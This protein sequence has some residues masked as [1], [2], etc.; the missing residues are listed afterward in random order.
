MTIPA[1]TELTAEARKAISDA[2][3]TIEKNLPFLRSLT[4][5]ERRGLMHMGDRNKAFVER[6]I[7]GAHIAPELLPRSIVIADFDRQL[8]LYRAL[9][10]ILARLISLSKLIEDTQDQVGDQLCSQSMEAYRY[11]KAAGR[12]EGL[13]ELIDSMGQRFNG[14]GRKKKTPPKDD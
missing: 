1:E 11:F 7:E 9:S 4:P 14:Q 2:F 13:D 5:D 10:P 6:T 8:A 12:T 3:D